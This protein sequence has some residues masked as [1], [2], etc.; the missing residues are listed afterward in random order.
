MNLESVGRASLG[1]NGVDLTA[2]ANGVIF[3]FDQ[4]IGKVSAYR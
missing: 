4:A 1:V 2:D 3:K